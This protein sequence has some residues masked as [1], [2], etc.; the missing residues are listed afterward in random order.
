MNFE[1][2]TSNINLI[3]KLDK[4]LFRTVQDSIGC[5]GF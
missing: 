4:F 2:D 3:A 5:I 1:G